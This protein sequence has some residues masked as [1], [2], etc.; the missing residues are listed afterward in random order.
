MKIAI[1]ITEDYDFTFDMLKDLIPKLK[2]NHTLTGIVSFPNKLK[3]YKGIAIYLTYLRIFGLLVFMKLVLRNLIKRF[4]ILI[5]Y[6]F[7]RCPFYSFRGMCHYYKLEKIHFP[8]PN[9]YSAIKW[10]KDNEIDIILISLGYILKSDII[11]APKI[12]ILNKHSGLLPAYKGI[13]PAFWTIMNN[14]K[15][16]V[17]IHKVTEKTDEGEIL[18]QKAY[19][20]YSCR[21]VYDYYKLIFSDMP[22]LVCESLQLIGNKQRKKIEHGIPPSYFGLPTKEDYIKFKSRG[23]KFV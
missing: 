10:V 21:S 1:F 3:K 8:N 13:F 20:M 9:H 16:G 14:D 6:V 7:R 2:K 23:Y 5:N 12:C 15:V 11:K 18:L 19:N 17:T 4:S 22:D